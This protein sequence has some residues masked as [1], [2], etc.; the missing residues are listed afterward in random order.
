RRPGRWRNVV[1]AGAGAGDAALHGRSRGRV[2]RLPAARFGRGFSRGTRPVFPAADD[3]RA[4]AGR[5]GT[6]P[7]AARRAVGPAAPRARGAARTR[8]ARGCLRRSRGRNTRGRPRPRRRA[9]PMR[10]SGYWLGLAGAGLTR[11]LG[12][13]WRTRITG[14]VEIGPRIYALPH[15]S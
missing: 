13:T 4:A 2:A 9:G 3:L 5:L 1:P 12:C 8:D 6:D 7:P 14:D 11:L 10:R 15:G